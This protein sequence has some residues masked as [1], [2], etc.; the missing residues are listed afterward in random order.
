MR[1]KQRLENL[2]LLV[3]QSLRITSYF[4]VRAD[5]S[6]R[7]GELESHLVVSSFN[8]PIVHQVERGR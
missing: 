7:K 8:I 1:T 2:G 6:A 3:S 5:S 4:L